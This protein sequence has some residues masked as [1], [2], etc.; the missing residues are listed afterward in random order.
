M[1]SNR[2]IAYRQTL[3]YNLFRLIGVWDRQDLKWQ[4]RRFRFDR[5]RK[6]RRNYDRTSIRHTSEED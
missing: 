2:D 1:Q 5:G 6:G 4:H 3:K